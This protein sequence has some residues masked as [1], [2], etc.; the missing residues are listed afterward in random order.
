MTGG[1][2][3]LNVCEAVTNLKSNKL[4]VSYTFIQMKMLSSLNSNMK[5]SPDIQ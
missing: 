3:M 2:M 1:K 5:K 4:Q